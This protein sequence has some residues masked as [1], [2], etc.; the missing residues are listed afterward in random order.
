MDERLEIKS[1]GNLNKYITPMPINFE[2]DS[3][4]EHD[5]DGKF[6][7]E[8]YGEE[9]LQQESIPLNELEDWKESSIAPKVK[10]TIELVEYELEK[11]HGSIKEEIILL[12]NRL[13]KA[14][15]DE[16]EDLAIEIEDELT[17]ILY[18]L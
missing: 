8:N 1:S 7:I 10:R 18:D 2:D 4:M 6:D 12:L 3:N 9:D 13:K 17:E 11:Q 5:I 14:T 15:I 16:D